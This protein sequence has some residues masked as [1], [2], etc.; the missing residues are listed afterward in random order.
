[1]DHRPEALKRAL[2]R[3]AEVDHLDMLI[4]LIG[5]EGDSP[6]RFDGVGKHG[7]AEV[8][9]DLGALRVLVEV[10]LGE[11]AEAFDTPETPEATSQGVAK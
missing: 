2:G 9:D 5:I 8:T 7:V 6:Q 11:M 1:M 10:A 3:I 4:G